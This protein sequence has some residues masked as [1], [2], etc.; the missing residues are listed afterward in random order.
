MSQISKLALAQSLHPEEQ[1]LQCFDEFDVDAMKHA[2]SLDI[3]KE[4]KTNLNYMWKHKLPP[5][6]KGMGYRFPVTYSL[7]DSGKQECMGR[8]YASPYYGFQKC[9]RPI[10]GIL[11]MKYNW[12]IDIKNCHPAILLQMCINNE[13]PHKAIEKLVNNREK[14]FLEWIKEKPKLDREQCKVIV[15]SLM[16]GGLVWSNYPTWVVKTLYPEIKKIMELMVKDNPTIHDYCLKECADSKRS[17]LGSTCAF[18]LQTEERRCMMAMKACMRE[19]DRVVNTLLHD[20]M[21]IRKLPNEGK[22]PEQILA[23][24]EMAIQLETGWGLELEVKPITSDIELPNAVVIP[25]GKSYLEMKVWIETNIFLVINASCFCDAGSDILRMMSKTNLIT[26]YGNKRF[27]GKDKKEKD[28][29]DLCFIDAWLA[30]D[31]IRSFNEIALIFPPTIC[32]ST[33]FNEWRGFA[34]EKIKS[35]PVN[36]YIRDGLKIVHSH[37]LLLANSQVDCYEFLTDW[38][39]FLLT[40]PGE[41][42]NVAILIKSKEGLGKGLLFEF[43]SSIIGS[44]YCYA[45][46]NPEFDF[47]GEFN[48]LLHNRLLVLADEMTP[49]L[50]KKYEGK[51]KSLITL[52]TIGIHYKGFSPLPNVT[53]YARVMMFSNEE[54]PIPL[55]DDDRRYLAIGFTGIIPPDDYFVTLRRV[56]NCPIIQ[57]A[58]FDE[59]IL[60]KVN[61][62]W[63]E[64]RPKTELADEIKAYSR[65]R[66]VD[67]IIDK[68]KTIREEYKE[69][70]WFFYDD[71]YN[72]CKDE[73]NDEVNEYKISKKAFTLKIDAFFPPG[74]W[75]DSKRE[76]KRVWIFHVQKTNAWLKDNGFPLI[77]SSLVERDKAVRFKLADK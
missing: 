62:K 75:T 73:A 37:L 23:D 1:T 39:A 25:V 15:L 76:K 10:R 50:G 46:A 63:K 40:K 33:T 69:D 58:F 45:T 56:F 21:Y 20:G 11:A 26:S 53:N 32:P 68:L 35:T 4:Q 55:K 9:S 52:P 3:D 64:D 38:I 5:K 67:F 17:P 66:E 31:N 41:R 44:K 22:F 19:K 70:A 54:I 74:L 12:D 30:D 61:R 27:W 13:W 42:C 7:T 72:G 71:L 36:D 47:F 8:F 24:C 6:A 43:L 16:F 65:S 77:Q 60:R 29:D 2:K 57:R 18:I 48:S 51:L 14:L 34:V 49:A 28:R 59:M